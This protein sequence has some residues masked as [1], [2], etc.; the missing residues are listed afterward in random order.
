[1]SVHCQQQCKI[2]WWK[3]AKLVQTDGIDSFKDIAILAVL[4][5]MS[6]RF[7][8]ADDIFKTRDN[9]LL[10]GRVAEV[11]TVERKNSDDASSLDMSTGHYDCDHVGHFRGTVRF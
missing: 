2:L 6:I 5:S 4:R 7:I 3:L 8:E 9:S 11:R 1:M 10:S